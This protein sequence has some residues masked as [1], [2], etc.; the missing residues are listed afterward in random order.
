MS[1]RC[2]NPGPRLHPH[3]GAAPVQTAELRSNRI[4]SYPLDR[5]LAR[6]SL[7]CFVQF[8]L[9]N[10]AY[11]PA[12]VSSLER[13]QNALLKPGNCLPA[14]GTGVQ[15]RCHRATLERALPLTRIF[16]PSG[17]HVSAVAAPSFTHQRRKNPVMFAM[18]RG[19]P[20]TA[21]AIPMQTTPAARQ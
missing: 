19:S 6:R 14:H 3:P 20:V 4:E 17:R 5:W 16:A 21:P 2:L 10:Q 18:C 15:A 13:L 8:S 7:S 11:R 1:C 9:G 12:C